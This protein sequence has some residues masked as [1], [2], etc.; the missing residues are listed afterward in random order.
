LVQII[1]IVHYA[2]LSTE[3]KGLANFLTPALYIITAITIIWL[4]NYDRLKG[5]FSTGLLF[6]FWLLVSVASVPDIMDYSFKFHQQVSHLHK[7]FHIN[8][9]LLCRSNQYHCG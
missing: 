5:V 1:R 4:V 6:L 2:V 3:A 7:Y 8:D 9:D